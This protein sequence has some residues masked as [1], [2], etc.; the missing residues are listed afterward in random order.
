MDFLGRKKWRLEFLHYR[1]PCC[2]ALTRTA[3]RIYQPEN[4]GQWKLDFSKSGVI[5]DLIAYSAFE[6]SLAL[7]R[8]QRLAV[9]SSLQESW[10]LAGAPEKFQEFQVH[11]KNSRN[12]KCLRSYVSACSW[13]KVNGKK[14]SVWTNWPLLKA[15]CAHIF[16]LA[17]KK[18]EIFAG[19]LGKST[20]PSFPTSL[21]EFPKFLGKF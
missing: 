12:E 14:W 20:F 10:S 4:L 7:Q 21:S 16:L 2:C 13:E 3:C 17:L 19:V 18:L 8:H 1:H 5:S 11:Q 9:Y 6:A 15:S